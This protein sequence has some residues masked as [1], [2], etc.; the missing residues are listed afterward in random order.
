[1]ESVLTL[2]DSLNLRCSGAALGRATVEMET[3]AVETAAIE[4]AREQWYTSLSST[5][6]GHCR[7]WLLVGVADG[8]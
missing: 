8:S 5:A 1:L 6:A 3:T 7:R 2:D 4:A